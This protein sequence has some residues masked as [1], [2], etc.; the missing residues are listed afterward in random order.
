MKHA[1]RSEEY[2]T[3]GDWSVEA[4]RALVG[5]EGPRI[6][7]LLDLAFTEF[8]DRHELSRWGFHGDD[9][10]EEAVEWCVERFGAEKPI[11]PGQLPTASRGFRLFTQPEWWLAQKVTTRGHRARL[12]ACRSRRTAGA[13]VRRRDADDEP[14]AEPSAGREGRGSTGMSDAGRR[15]EDRMADAL[16]STRFP[17]RLRS[18]LRVLFRRTCADIVGFWL[19]GTASWRAR[20]FDWNEPCS[21]EEFEVAG[22]ALSF[23][24]HDAL[25]RF[26]CVFLNLFH[27]QSE[28]AQVVV[29]TMFSGVPNAPPYRQADRDVLGALDGVAASGPRAVTRLRKAGCADLLVA[30]MDRLRRFPRGDLARDLGTASISKT[31]LWALDIADRGDLVAALE[32]FIGEHAHG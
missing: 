11:D 28:S 16:D 15:A 19:R 27:T 7:A 29:A 21:A 13:D 25:F 26:Q 31:T 17:D 12:A 10:V 5:A 30:V 1:P 24:V 2:P 20:M 9:P 32:A 22:K 18:T 6:R 3:I 8:C 23:R 4:R 14:S